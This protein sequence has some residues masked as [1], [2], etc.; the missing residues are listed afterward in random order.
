[1][2]LL[3][4]RHGKTQFN[5]EDRFQGVSDSPLTNEGIEKAKQLNLFL[6]DNFD[7]KKFYISPAPRV[8]QTLEIASQGI[9]AEVE[10]TNELREVCYGEWESQTRDKID[11]DLLKQRSDDRFNF[12]HPGEYNGIKGESYRMQYERLLPFFYKLIHELQ[13]IEDIAVVSHHGVMICLLR[14]L[15]HLS[16]DDLDELRIPN[17]KVIVVDFIDGKPVINLREI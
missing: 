2:S 13:P 4:C 5:L 12:V 10:V 9:H 3:F 17:N 7:I 1:M 6:L 15:E 16:D 8:K 14:Y 11:K